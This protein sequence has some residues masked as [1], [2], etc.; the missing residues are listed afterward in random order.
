MNADQLPPDMTD[1]RPR[2]LVIGGSVGGLFV[3]H[4]LRQMGWDALV[5]ERSS[6]DLASRGAGIG[7]SEALFAVLRRIGVAVDLSNG[8]EVRSRICLDQR[9]EIVHELPVHSVTSSWD[10]IY[11]PLR[12][13]FP[14]DQYR[15]GMVLERVEQNEQS[16]TAVF[17][18][19]SRVTGDLLAGADGSESAVRQQFL[20][21]VQ[22]RYAGYV[23]W[24]FVAEQHD[25]PP[26]AHA[27]LDGRFGCCLPDGE[28][29]IALTIP[30]PG[31]DTREGRH[32]HY[33]GWFRPADEEQ[34]LTDLFTDI[35]GRRH[36]N[37][38]PPP[39]IRPEIVADLKARA[40]ALLAPQVAAI[41][42]GATQP[43]LQAVSDLESSS[44]GLRAGNPTRRCGLRRSAAR[45][46]WGDEGGARRAEPRGRVRGSAGRPCSSAH[47]LRTRA[48]VVRERTRRARSSPRSVFG[49]AAQ[50][51]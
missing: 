1:V 26:V 36:G 45:C 23:N 5:F 46:R 8:I 25:V 44:T 48:A 14:P 50:A 4:L 33:V 51:L 11:R 13:A 9:G 2:A 17:A 31:G 49:G 6:G 7:T 16:V 29:A 10:S 22:P 19:G 3:G 42:D 43:L 28:L 39:L 30:G 47:S 18:D 32:R 24:R 34:T 21:Q 20:P 27:T 37:S 40:R 38:I 41:I 12:Q 35:P 15:A